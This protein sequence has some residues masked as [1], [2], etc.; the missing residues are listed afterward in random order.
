MD[1]SL[2]QIVGTKFFT[3]NDMAEKEKR[4]E[5]AYSEC[6]KY[7]ENREQCWNKFEN[8]SQNDNCFDEELAEKKCLASHLCPELYKKFYE[9]SE[10]HLW[11]AAFRK[12][13]DNR[14]MEARKRIDNDRAMSNMCRELGHE[15]SKEL[16]NYSKYRPEAFEG[17]SFL[18]KNLMK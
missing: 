17:Q 15:L 13:H 14:Y 16:S 2:N 6:S 3:G 8:R 18:K 1:C 10:C 4:A 5:K 11:A 12:R 9:Y 7:I